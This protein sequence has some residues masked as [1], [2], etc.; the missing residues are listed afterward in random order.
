MTAYNPMQLGCIRFQDAKKCLDLTDLS[1][2]GGFWPSQTITSSLSAKSSSFRRIS[3]TQEP[4]LKSI[5]GM[6]MSGLTPL[7][8]SEL[9]LL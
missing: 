6:V 1:R 8:F 9:G 5:A 4:H 3:Y 7:P 2:S